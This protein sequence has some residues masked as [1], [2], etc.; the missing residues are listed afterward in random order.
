MGY[1]HGSTAADRLSALADLTVTRIGAEEVLARLRRGE[2]IVF[3]DARR[4]EEWK[5]ATEKLPG[6]VRLAPDRA[7]ET[8][9]IIPPGYTA[10]AY[11]TCP[12]EA[13]AVGAAELLFAQGYDDV[14]VLYGGLAAWRLAGG[15]MEPK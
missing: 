8:L 14:H 10:V 6:A 4:E 3:I 12:A 2:P 7:D 11:C 9:P 13:S 1:A 15:P 5:R